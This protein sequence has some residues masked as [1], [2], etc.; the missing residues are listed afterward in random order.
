LR[1]DPAQQRQPVAAA[2]HRLDHE[3]LAAQRFRERRLRVRQRLRVN[4]GVHEDAH[5]PEHDALRS[6]ELRERLLEQLAVG[7]ER[8]ELAEHLE[9]SAVRLASALSDRV[10]QFLECGVG[11][12]RQGFG[13][14]HVGHPGVHVLA[15]DADEVR[16]VVD[17]QSVG[18]DLVHQV[19]GLAGVQPLGDHRLVADRE[20]DE[21]PRRCCSAP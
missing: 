5:V 2:A 20:P 1:G 12:D 18:V 13:G 16:P 8:P 6:G 4:R 7:L 14:P 3:T 21:S 9:Q 17:A 10:Q 11:V 15:G 19:S